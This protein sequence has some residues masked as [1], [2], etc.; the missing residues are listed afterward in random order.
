VIPRG[1]VVT[2]PMCEDLIE[3]DVC[4]WSMSVGESEESGKGLLLEAM[5]WAQHDC[6]PGRKAP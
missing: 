1:L 2:C 4:G 3:L 5:A 6:Q